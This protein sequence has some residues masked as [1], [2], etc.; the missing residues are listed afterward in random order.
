MKSVGLEAH[1]FRCTDILVI[2]I[3]SFKTLRQTARDTLVNSKFKILSQLYHSDKNPYNSSPEFVL[4]HNDKMLESN[5]QS[6]Q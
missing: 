3:V 4:E 5:S 2:D 6:K 1:S